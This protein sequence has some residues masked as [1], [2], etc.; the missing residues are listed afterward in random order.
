[1]I[2]IFSG[3]FRVD[4]THFWWCPAEARICSAT[5]GA[6]PANRSPIHAWRRKP[7]A[8]C[9]C[10]DSFWCYSDYDLMSFLLRFAMVVGY[11]CL[12]QSLIVF[13]DWERSVLVD[14]LARCFLIQLKIAIGWATNNLLANVLNNGA[15]GLPMSLTG[16]SNKSVDAPLWVLMG[17]VEQWCLQTLSFS[18]IEVSSPYMGKPP[19]YV[20]V[21]HLLELVWYWIYSFSGRS[22]GVERI[23]GG[24]I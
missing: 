22:L 5:S 13:T 2:N 18:V 9:G 21:G 19:P 16:Y 3:G 11:C 10:R 15:V 23:A 1:M 17:F 8:A 4:T 12:K 7:K 14:K 6:A 20:D 24:Y